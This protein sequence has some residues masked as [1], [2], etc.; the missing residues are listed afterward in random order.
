MA[1]GG[2]VPRRLSKHPSGLLSTQRCSE[3][4]FLYMQDHVS[5]ECRIP[6]TG[7][8]LN[9]SRLFSFPAFLAY[10]F[11]SWLDCFTSFARRPPHT[12][13]RSYSSSFPSTLP[14][15]DPSTA[16]FVS[17]TQHVRSSIGGTH[18]DARTHACHRLLESRSARR[19]S[20]L[21]STSLAA[22]VPARI[23][24]SEVTCLP[25]FFRLFPLRVFPQYDAGVP[26]Y[27]A[28]VHP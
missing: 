18:I 1:L 26:V 15:V 22:T 19:R 13:A 3:W 5:R 6:R 20:P 17:S 27:V 7:V 2:A 24:F 25:V 9:C 21:L 28:S 23:T 14:R 8:V 10:F 4:S 12:H 11:P 16:Y